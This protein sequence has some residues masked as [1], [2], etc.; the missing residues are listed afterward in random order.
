MLIAY[1]IAFNTL[2]TFLCM[3]PNN[4]FLHNSIFFQKDVT[5]FSKLTIRWCYVFCCMLCTVSLKCIWMDLRWAW[6]MTITPAQYPIRPIRKYKKEKN[7]ASPFWEN[8][9]SF[10]FF[11]SNWHFGLLEKKRLLEVKISE[12]TF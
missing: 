1:L 9:N 2:V 7:S 12:L 3:L 5:F 10:L 8:Y 6:G 11:Y 4:I